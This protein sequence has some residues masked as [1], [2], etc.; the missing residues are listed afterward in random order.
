MARGKKAD[1]ITTLQTTAIVVCFMLAAGLLTLPRVAVEVAKT[2]DAWISVILAGAATFLFGWIMIKL[3]S[4][5]PETTFYQYVQRITGKVIGKGIG[6]LIVIY[7]VCIAAF[8]IRSVEEV[9]SF[10][11][12]EGTPA[13]AISA[14]FMWLSLYLCMGGVGALGKICQLVF[15]VTAAIF[16]LICLL[17]LNIFELNNL[18][19]VLSE[20]AMPVLRTLKTTIL[21]LTGTESLL[22]IYCRMEKPEKA[23]K[24]IGLAIGIAVAFYTATLILC[25]GAFS[26][27]GLL[28]RT[29]P[30]LDLAR[31]FEVEYL[32]LERFESLLLTI[33]IMQIFA[34]FSIAFYCASLG[35]SQILNSSY[36]KMLFILL[37]FI[38]LLSQIPKNL[39]ELF[40]FGTVIGNV[41]FALFALLPLPLLLISYWRGARS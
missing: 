20:G 11:L 16:L 6:M 28:S 24:A 37:P 22:F 35:V 36:S 25:I 27:E 4:R 7:F 14:P 26:I 17:S 1:K 5:F 30:F 2:P 19:P 29:W 40:S 32:L 38:Y 15:P 12:L 13:W 41:A 34:T 9:T 39:N 3:S 33:W 10:F 31:S 23:T 21:T 18:R 8:E